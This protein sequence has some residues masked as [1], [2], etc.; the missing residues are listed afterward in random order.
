LA[1][2]GTGVCEE[3]GLD[4]GKKADRFSIK[5]IESVLLVLRKLVEGSLGILTIGRHGC[6]WESFSGKKQYVGEMREPGGAQGIERVGNILSTPVQEEQG[7]AAIGD[8]P[9]INQAKLN[10]IFGFAQPEEDRLGSCSA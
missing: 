7:V 9:G 5:H 6:A 2:A 1:S 10:E 3:L 4:R 8:F